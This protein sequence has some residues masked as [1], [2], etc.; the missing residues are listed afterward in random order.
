MLEDLFKLVK[1]RFNDEE[2]VAQETKKVDIPS[3]LMFKCPRCQNVCFQEEFDKINK[4]CPVCNYH[5]RISAR[6]RLEIT[7]DKGTFVE[8]DSE[9]K[10][11]NP[12]DFPKIS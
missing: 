8:Y 11:K 3:D 2:P 4:V 9:M 10:S 7:V 5:A 1:T 12:I 6:E